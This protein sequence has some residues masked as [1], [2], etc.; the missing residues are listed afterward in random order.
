M[1]KLIV[2]YHWGPQQPHYKHKSLSVLAPTCKIFLF[3]LL[4]VF[5]E[6]IYLPIYT[7]KYIYTYIYLRMYIGKYIY[8]NIYISHIYIY[9]YIYNTYIY[10]YI[11]I[12]ISMSNM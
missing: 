12:Y 9:K 4:S 7:L 3:R 5:L 6:N 8:I 1:Q 10:I 11:Y 2:Y